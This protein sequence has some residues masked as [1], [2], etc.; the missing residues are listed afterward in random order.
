MS[1]YIIAHVQVTNPVQYEESKK[2]STA[3]IMRMVAAESI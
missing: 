1:A 2:W 3:A